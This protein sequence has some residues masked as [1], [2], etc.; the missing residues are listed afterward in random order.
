MVLVFMCENNGIQVPDP[1]S[2][3]LLP[4]VG[5]GVYHQAQVIRLDMDGRSE[6]L[7]SEVK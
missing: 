4:E 1:F 3:H 6:S 2:E 7:I 5:A